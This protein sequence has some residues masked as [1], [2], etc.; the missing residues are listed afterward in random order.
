MDDVNRYIFYTLGTL[1]CIVL[2]FLAYGIYVNWKKGKQSSM[3]LVEIIP[4]ILS[5]KL[6]DYIEQFNNLHK[7]SKK[8]HIDIMDGEYVDTRSPAA[9]EIAYKLSYA[10]N[11]EFAYHLMVKNPLYILNDLDRYKNIRL[12]YLHAETINEDFFNFE[13][14]FEI[15]PAFNPDTN[16][17]MYAHLLSK[18]SKVLVMT[19]Q[20]GKQGNPFVPEALENINRLRLLGFQGEI[21]IDGHINEETIP[22]IM[23][24]RP[25][26]LNV[27]SA[28]SKSKQP[29]K[30][31]FKLMNMVK[32]L[33]S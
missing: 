20:P 32:E 23:K 6:D 16:I 17:E 3:Q 5:E 25:D 1:I 11:T 30:E 24:Y 18:V 4:A 15:V 19:I 33:K 28:I 7:I 29:V 21:H 14:P 31:Y 10:V 12:V 27:G 8:I 13:Y 26:V 9:E 2:I 22:T